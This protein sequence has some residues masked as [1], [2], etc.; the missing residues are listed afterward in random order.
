M[1][2]GRLHGEGNKGA[3]RNGAGDGERARP[4]TGAVLVGD[5][6]PVRRAGAAA[7]RGRPA[8]RAGRLRRR[9][10]RPPRRLALAAG[11][12]RDRPPRRPDGA[13]A[14]LAGAPD[15]ARDGARGRQPRRCSTCWARAGAGCRCCGRSRRRA[16]SRRSGSFPTRPAGGA[17]VEAGRHQRGHRVRGLPARSMVYAPVAADRGLA[18]GPQPPPAASRSCRASPSSRA[19]PAWKAPS[20][21]GGRRRLGSRRARTPP[22]AWRP[23]SWKQL[24]AWR[25]RLAR[26]PR[27]P[28]K[29]SPRSARR[30]SPRFVAHRPRKIG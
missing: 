20:R 22:P 18:V 29:A 6:A 9:R 27:R 28:V 23:P 24:P 8:R 1:L 19:P 13:P 5:A 3:R 4:G 10:V 30:G 26:Q 21:L 14:P 16:S 12:D 15:R 11:R 7:R 17:A 2:T 25:R